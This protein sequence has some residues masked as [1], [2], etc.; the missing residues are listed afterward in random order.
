VFR[1]VSPASSVIFFLLKKNL[2]PKDWLCG[3]KI[4][5][6]PGTTTTKK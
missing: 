6:S 4:Y 1:F 2:V 5:I 3:A